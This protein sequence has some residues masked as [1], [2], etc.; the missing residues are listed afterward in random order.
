[1]SLSARKLLGRDS[2]TRGC[3]N[4]CGTAAAAALCSTHRESRSVRHRRNGEVSCNRWPSNCERF[5]SKVSRARTAHGTRHTARP[6]KRRTCNRVAMCGRFPCCITARRGCQETNTH[7]LASHA[8]N[9]TPPAQGV[10]SHRRLCQPKAMLTEGNLVQSDHPLFVW[11]YSIDSRLYCRDFRGHS[12]EVGDII[13]TLPYGCQW[14]R[15]AS[16]VYHSS[17]STKR[18]HIGTAG[19]AQATCGPAVIM[20]PPTP[21][22]SQGYHYPLTTHVHTCYVPLPHG[23]AHGMA[24]GMLP[25]MPHGPAPLAGT[26]AGT[27][28]IW[29]PLSNAYAPP[30]SRSMASM[31]STAPMPVVHVNPAYSMASGPTVGYTVA[32]HAHG[33]CI[34]HYKSTWRIIWIRDVFCYRI[35]APKVP[36]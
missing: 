8:A 29:M 35:P 34:T 6:R 25:A 30:M 1:M 14:Y 11:L 4:K 13:I 32:G 2:I 31:A 20:L 7:S 24:H 19:M 9:C 23:M 26:M 12:F 28:G 17:P 27:A 3:G 15:C 16:V 36:G 5:S 10:A 18:I 22:A 33:Q 21:H